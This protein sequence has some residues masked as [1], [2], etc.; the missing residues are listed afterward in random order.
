MRSGTKRSLVVFPLIL[1]LLVAGCTSWRSVELPVGDMRT[2]IRAGE[3]VS[4]GDE[5]M[6]T[7]ATGQEHTFKVVSVDQDTI[8]GESVVV[9]IDDIA[10][11]RMQQVSSGKTALGVGVGTIVTYVIVAGIAFM[12]ALSD[13]LDAD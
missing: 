5:V 9:R 1:S 8:R 3:L 11:M 6:I 4:A 7:T 10:A 13:A 12:V 2:R